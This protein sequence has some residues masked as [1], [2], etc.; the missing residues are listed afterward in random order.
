MIDRYHTGSDIQ[1][2]FSISTKTPHSKSHS[3]SKMASKISTH[4]LS[5][6]IPKPI[7]VSA[8]SNIVP[9]SHSPISIV[10]T[11]DQTCEALS[12]SPS[13]LRRYET[14]VPNF[15]KRVRLGRRRIGYLRVDIERY[16]ACQREA[17]IG[18]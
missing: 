16:I 12:I 10:L 11:T 4:L 7:M 15:P 2:F 17:S 9:T 5:R 3:M 13:S 18:Q 1:R 8:F 14:T 6:S